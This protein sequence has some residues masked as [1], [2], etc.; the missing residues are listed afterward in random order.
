MDNISSCIFHPFE[1]YPELI[2]YLSL[3]SRQEM[4]KAL[5]STNIFC[6]VLIIN[7]LAPLK[8]YTFIGKGTFVF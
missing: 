5:S 8:L 2:G 6:L 3:Y 1:R 7:Q 4:E